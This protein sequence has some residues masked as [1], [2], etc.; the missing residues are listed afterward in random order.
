MATLTNGLHATTAA[1]VAP[2]CRPASVYASGGKR[3]LD[4][5]VSLGA[6]AVLSPVMLCCALLVRLTSRGPVFFRQTRV[7]R[8]GRSFAL[9]KFRSMLHGVEALGAASGA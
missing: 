4:A 2:D 7:G 1:R 6:L 3:C 8:Q 5:A 9:I